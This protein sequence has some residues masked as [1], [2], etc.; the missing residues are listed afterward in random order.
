MNQSIH[1][2][3][4]STLQGERAV[5]PFAAAVADWAGAWFAARGWR[6]AATFQ[7]AGDGGNWTVLRDDPLYSV[8]GQP[9][10]TLDLAFAILSQRPRQ[11]LTPS[12]QQLLRRLAAAALDDLHKRIAALY[13]A[14]LRQSAGLGARERLRLAIGP[15]HQPQLGVE[16]DLGGLTAL[17]R[18][19]FRAVRPR[20]EL[21]PAR[22]AVAQQP[23]RVEAHLGSAA[24]SIA[25]IETLEIGDIVVLDRPLTAP[26][27]LS[28]NNRFGTMPFALSDDGQ[29][30]ILTLQD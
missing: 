20:G 5:R 19:G 21:I 12:D 23:V 25:Q 24:L 2:L 18:G 9:K 15:D 6:A 28:I 27:R 11:E 1:W 30:I 7:P 8:V 26:A 16:V 14:G 13:P 29:N 3:P 22:T 17:V 10:V 4:K